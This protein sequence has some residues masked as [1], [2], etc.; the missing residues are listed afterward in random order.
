MNEEALADF[1]GYENYD[2]VPPAFVSARTSLL[3][4]RS[5]KVERRSRQPPEICEADSDEAFQ[6]FH[7]E[8]AEGKNW[9]N[10]MAKHTYAIVD[11]QSRRNKS[12]VICFLKREFEEYWDDPAV[13]KYGLRVVDQR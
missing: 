1:G 9:K 10:W 3:E 11:E 6:H 12:V 13:G 5:R 2:H 8:V 7:Y 4:K